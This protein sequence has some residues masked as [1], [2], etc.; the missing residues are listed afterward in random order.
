[1]ARQH[2]LGPERKDGVQRVDVIERP[3]RHRSPQRVQVRERFVVVVA[4]ERRL[5]LRN[6]DRQVIRRLARRVNQIEFDVADR[7][8]IAIV[9]RPRRLERRLRGSGRRRCA[10]AEL[11]RVAPSK[12]LGKHALVAC[13]RRMIALR[14]DLGSR[15][16]PDPDAARVV[17]VRVRQHDGLH[18]RR[19]LRGQRLFVCGRGRGKESAYEVQ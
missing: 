17:A 10:E 11:G 5:E 4:D 12:E 19:A 13:K 18:R 7:Q 1:M 8:R 2:E 16:A 3:S 15:F 6:P 14:D 9:E